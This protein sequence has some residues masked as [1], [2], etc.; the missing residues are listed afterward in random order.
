MLAQSLAA[1]G[2]HREALTARWRRVVRIAAH[3]ERRREGLGR[4]LLVADMASAAE[5]GVALYGA[6]FGAEAG[7]L[8]FWLALG[9]TPV[10]LGVTRE[11]ATGEYA[12]MVAKPLNEIGQAV[13]HSMQQGFVASLQG[14]LAFELRDLPAPVVAL[15]LSELPERPLSAVERQTIHDVAYAHR[16]PALAR[17]ALQA[18]GREASRAPLGEAR[19]AHQQLV[20]WAY[21]NQPLADAPREA[22]QQ[23]RRVTQQLMTASMLFSDGQE[24]LK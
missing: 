16:D 13:L 22:T 9:F 10:R 6:T 15:L 7:L 3:P 2:G 1:H 14:L 12:I 11:A 5:Q 19:L 8:S 17:A 21:Q 18:L 4:R 23:L 24:R 20:A